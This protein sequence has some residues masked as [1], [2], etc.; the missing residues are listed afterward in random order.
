MI[1]PAQLAHVEM[2]RVLAAGIV[3]WVRA[4]KTAYT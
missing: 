3:L 4:E 2:R 1:R